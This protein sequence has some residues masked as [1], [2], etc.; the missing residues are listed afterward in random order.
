MTDDRGRL[1]VLDD[2]HGYASV[3]ASAGG[4][5]DRADRLR[6]PALA[7]DHA[8]EVVVGH[9]DFEHELALL[10]VLVDLD[11]IGA[12]DDRADQVFDELGGGRSQ[13]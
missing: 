3:L 6:D 9:L 13:S 11:V 2:I 12:F 8:T 4:A 7:P 10:L 1:F 5:R